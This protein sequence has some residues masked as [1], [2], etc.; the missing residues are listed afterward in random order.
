MLQ[1]TLSSVTMQ[2]QKC[3]QEDLIEELMCDGFRSSLPPGFHCCLAEYF[4]RGGQFKR[5]VVW[6]KISIGYSLSV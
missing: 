2:Q 4:V 1:S 3:F 5:S 6:N